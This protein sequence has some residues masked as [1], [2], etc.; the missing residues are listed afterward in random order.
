VHLA[1]CRFVKVLAGFEASW[2][3]F[4]LCLATSTLCWSVKPTYDAD[5]AF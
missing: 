4:S 3:G 2:V 1:G 5:R